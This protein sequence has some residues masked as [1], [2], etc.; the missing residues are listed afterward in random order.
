MSNNIDWGYFIIT[1]EEYLSENNISKNFVM[2]NANMQ[3]TQLNNYCK[4]KVVRP[5]LGVLAR[6]CFALNCDL[7][8][9]IKYV[10]PNKSKDAQIPNTSNNLS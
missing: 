8:Q 3:R 6:I 2:Y 5:D 4:N 10:P 1:L 9:I 7:S